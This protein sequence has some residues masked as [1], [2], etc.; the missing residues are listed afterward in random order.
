MGAE[1]IIC[2]KTE[3]KFLTE[4][5]YDV[6]LVFFVFLNKTHKMACCAVGFGHTERSEIGEH[7]EE[8][9]SSDTNRVTRTDRTDGEKPPYELVARQLEFLLCFV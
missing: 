3:S 9:E 7:G 8:L 2:T 4:L 1:L 6:V 5:Q